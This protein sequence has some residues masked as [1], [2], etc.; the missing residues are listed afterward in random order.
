[1][2]LA[3]ALAAAAIVAPAPGETDLA[4]A[5]PQGERAALWPDD[6][7]DPAIPRLAAV[8]GHDFGADITRSDDLRRYFEALA[9]AAPDRMRLVDIG[10]TWQGRPLYYAIIGAPESLARLDEIKA[11]MQALADPRKTAPQ[12]AERLVETLPAIVWLAHSV[13][14]DE[15]GPADAAALTAYHLLA[16]RRDPRVPQML[17]ETLIIINPLQNPDGRDRF[18]AA[19]VAAR[20]LAADPDPLAAERDQPW[21]GGRTNHYLFDLNRDWFAQTQPESK[22]HARAVLEW[23]PQILVD[24]HEMGTDET[25]FFPPAAPPTNPFQTPAQMR[26]RDAVGR[27]IAS[28]FDKLSF[29]Y[30][31]REIFDLFYPGYADGWPSYHGAAAMTFEQGSARGLMARRR[32]GEI[33]TYAQTVES[34]VAAALATIETAAANRRRLLAEFVDY[35]RSAIAENRASVRRTIVIP[36]QADQSGADALAQALKAQGIEIA[37]AEGPIAACGRKVEAGSYVIDS[38]QPAGRLLRVLTDEQV[39]MERAFVQRQEMLRAMGRPDEFYDVTAWSLPM[40][41][42]LQTIS[43]GA[44][45]PAGLAPLEAIAPIGAVENPQGAYGFAIPWGEASAIRF[46]AGALQA[47]LRLKSA[48]APFTHAGRTYPSG[49][50]VIARADNGQDLTATIS[51]LASETGARVFGL[52]GSWVSEGPSFGSPRMRAMPAPRIAL[53]WDEPTNPSAAGAVRFVIERRF[54][55]PV[56]AIRA[57]RLAGADLTGFD[58]LILPSGDYGDLG[59]G[60]E[61]A[62]WVRR[63]GTIIGIGE[64]LRFLA[65]PEANLLSVRREEAFADGS[66]DGE[67]ETDGHTRPGTIL[68]SP[69]ERRAAAAPRGAA[70]DAPS[71]ALLRVETESEHWMAAGLAPTLHVLVQGGDIYTPVTR[72]EGDAVASFAGPD[73]LLASGYVWEE[74][75]RQMA[76]KPF[77][78][79]EPEGGGSVIGFTADPTL[80]GFMYGLDVILANAIFRG[81]ARADRAKR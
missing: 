20:G 37:R 19:N 61:L 23:T 39:P 55:Y 35:R 59:E 31:T 63:G 18:I 21:P 68:T 11:G 41:Y 56:T 48:D 4:P 52:D 15:V 76:Y 65:S 46:L 42:N 69:A 28:W 29:D 16:A 51:R 72:D 32:D 25:F 43:C 38:A 54:G 74:T 57:E 7:Y 49:S 22:A 81:A 50:L 64:A 73:A 5:L 6:S 13:H 8:A 30:F 44:A 67:V 75:Q 77:A 26:T 2:F 17:R 80:R 53:A 36:A 24:L 79:V 40:L 1:M 60:R 3:S 34:Q 62:D 33:L 10:R 47:G 14:G 12:D 9:A 58:V 70:P 71:G 66:S 27:G 45:P 78:I